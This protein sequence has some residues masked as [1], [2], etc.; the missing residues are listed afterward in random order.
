MS[1]TRN[2]YDNNLKWN[3]E[4]LYP[5]T[6]EFNKAYNDLEKRLNEFESFRG[7]I[8][9]DAK[10]LYKLL[11]FDT[12]IERNIE[13]IY[14]YSHIQSDQDKTD[15]DAQNIY[16]RANKLYEKYSEVTSFIVPEILLSTFEKIEQYIQELPNL[17]SYRRLL[18]E[19]FKLK[20]HTLS[21]QEEGILSSLSNS[22]GTP[23]EIHSLLTD[24]DLS[25]GKIKNENNEEV[26]LNEKNYVEFIKNS[27]RKVRK[28]AFEKL[29]STFGNFKNTYA[30][31]LSN[32][33]Q[34]DNK[35]A[36]IRK[37]ESA[38]EASLF[39]NDIPI[40][41]YSNL[42]ESV[43]RNISPLSKF[44]NLKKRALKVDELHIYDTYAPIVKSINKK[45]SEEEARQIIRDA[46]NVL[47]EDYIKNLDR[48]FAERWIDFPPN[49]GKRNGAYCTTCYNVHPYVLVNFNNTLDSVSTL[50]HE[51]GHA[52]HSLY[53]IENQ[54]YQDYNYTIFVAEVASQVNQILLSKYLIENSDDD[55]L[56]KYLLDD[57]IQD[58][59][60]TIYR[61]TMFADFE[62]TIHEMDQRGEI[63]THEN[64]CNTYFD[65]NKTYYGEN[66]IIDESIKY[67]WERIPH[68]YTS[69][70]VYQY[71]TSYVA[72]IKIVQDILNKKEGTVERYLEFLKLGCTK[73]PIESLKVAGVD[74]SKSETL[75]EAFVYFNDLIEELSKLYK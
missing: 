65:L 55:E 8:L 23:D 62:R 42:L 12:E 26:E 4:D 68:F 11:S 59:K 70:Y 19:L 14:I 58:F 22:F 21:T 48:A 73:D 25:F 34:N 36:R 15:T 71:A 67:E 53:A 74:M 33:V 13:Q 30:A 61:Q 72:S 40:E 56:K 31:L 52:M 17:E 6:D 37:Y 27:D 38:L 18:K 39:N 2:K 16:G 10:T 7:H 5:N 3:I 45:Y 75:D 41:I 43:K 63:L 57:L 44:W 51:L 69:Y 66:I 64:M 29:L 1:N 47:G 20:E 24:A 32:A 54:S 60:S 46:L 50:A 35:L 49:E 9:D 28:A